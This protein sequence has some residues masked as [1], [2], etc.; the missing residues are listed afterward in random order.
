MLGRCDPGKD[1]DRGCSRRSPDFRRLLGL[2]RPSG[3]KTS[4]STVNL[5]PED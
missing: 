2:F 3:K 4:P 1:G 5:G